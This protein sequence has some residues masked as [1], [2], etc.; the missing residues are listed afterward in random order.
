MTRL[1]LHPPEAVACL[2][3]RRVDPE[4]ADKVRFPADSERMVSAALSRTLVAERIRHLVC[5]A[6]CGADILALEACAA[7]DVAATIVLPF[8]AADFRRMSVV[9]RPG[10]WGPR[11]DR[12]L[13]R[14]RAAGT[15]IELA[16]SLRDD[17]AFER[18][19][20]EIVSTAADMDSGRRLAVIVWDGR[21]VGEEDV[22]GHVRDLAAARGFDV[23]E[24]STLPNVGSAS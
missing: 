12:V 5:S 2:A 22:T 4:H 3:G 19:N 13:A 17:S 9:D 10:D 16:P 14:A 23:V 20:V 15:V 1:D 7:A 24:V 6:A 21:K 18:A 11:F 8:A